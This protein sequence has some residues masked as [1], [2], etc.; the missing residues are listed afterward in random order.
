MIDSF[1]TIPER[2]SARISRKRSR[3]HSFVLPVETLEDVDRELGALRREH[4]D[5]AHVCSAYRLRGES[6]ALSGSA[7]DGE[8]SGSAGLPI[9]QQLEK[10]GIVDV[11]AAVVRYF[12]GVKLGV[13]GLVRAY[14]DAVA[15]A[16]STTTIVERR[17]ETRLR[18]TYEPSLT[19]AVMQTIHRLDANVER[20]EYDSEA[21]AVVTVPPSRA[22]AFVDG[23]REATGGRAKAEVSG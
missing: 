15:E 11:L 18:I 16:L 13:G 8:P 10:A 7:D 3:F 12:G 21:V 6:A 14:S 20:I 19:S 1:H 5:A 23:L 2:V 17:L 22:C 9:L 4:R